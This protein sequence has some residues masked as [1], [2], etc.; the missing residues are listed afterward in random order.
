MHTNPDS[1]DYTPV[2]HALNI[3]SLA[4]CWHVYNLFFFPN[5]LPAKM[6]SIIPNKFQ[7]LSELQS[8]ID[9]TR[10]H[11]VTTVNTICCC[12]RFREH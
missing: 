3:S 7:S 11:Q 9:R 6:Y 1:S 10:D 5:F 4:D 12:V 2:L 8:G